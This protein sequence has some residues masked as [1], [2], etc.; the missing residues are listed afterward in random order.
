MREA[1]YQMPKFAVQLTRTTTSTSLG[2]GSV[3]IPS[4]GSHRF[5]LMEF[6]FGSDAATLGTSYFRLEV[7]RS[8][9]PATS[10][11]LVT[12]TPLED[13]SDSIAIQP[14]KELTANGTLSGSAL[15]TMA[16]AEQATFRYVAYPGS[17]IIVP[18]VPFAGIH[19]LTPV[20][21]NT[22][23]VAVHLIVEGL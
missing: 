10:S 7:Q 8:T 4:G 2:I 17:E 13:P 1:S 19:F 9:G 18:G 14:K 3:E 5:K 22:P 6:E 12:P 21:G 15:I 20:C 11:N 16:I 23:S